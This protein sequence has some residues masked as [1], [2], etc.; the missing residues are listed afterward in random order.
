[1]Q[2][3]AVPGEGTDSR[4][5]GRTGG[6]HKISV[7]SLSMYMPSRSPVPGSRPGHGTGQAAPIAYPISA[8]WRL[9]RLCSGHVISSRNHRFR[10]LKNPPI[11]RILVLTL[12][13]SGYV[14]GSRNHSRDPGRERTR[15]GLF[16]G[17]RCAWRPAP[18]GG[19]G[20]P[21]PG[22]GLW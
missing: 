16:P 13:C 15:A 5:G 22:P 4:A 9:P 19:S 17:S 20:D 21:G 7:D 10:L 11:I 8:S 1:M 12:L 2:A 6:A 3:T 18:A 14:T